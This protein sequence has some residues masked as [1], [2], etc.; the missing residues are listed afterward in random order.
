MDPR[1]ATRTWESAE[2][3]TRPEGAD[4]DGVGIFAILEKPDGTL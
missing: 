4:I 1:G 2:R 3:S